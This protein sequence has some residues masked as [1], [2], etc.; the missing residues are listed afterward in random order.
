[1]TKDEFLDRWAKRATDGKSVESFER[2][3]EALLMTTIRTTATAVT[4]GLNSAA[5]HAPS[6]AQERIVR[7][8]AVNLIPAVES[9]LMKAHGIEEEGDSNAPGN[10]AGPSRR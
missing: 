5:D 4:S 9:A 3:V 8:L 6:I 7:M 2:D 10:A 1:V